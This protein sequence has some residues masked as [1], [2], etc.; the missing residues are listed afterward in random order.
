MTEPWQ[1]FSPAAPGATPRCPQPCRPRPGAPYPEPRW[2]AHSLAACEG[3]LILVDA[4]QG[5]ASTNQDVLAV[6]GPLADTGHRADGHLAP[7][8]ARLAVLGVVAQYRLP[9]DEEAEGSRG[10]SSRLSSPLG[11]TTRSAAKPAPLP[12]T[13][14]GVIRRP[15]CEPAAEEDRGGGHGHLHAR[16]KPRDPRASQST[17]LPPTSKR[18]LGR[19]RRALEAMREPVCLLWD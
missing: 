12:L 3:V 6:P 2:P 18:S 9:E 14:E 19:Q 4:T 17:I 7:R 5:E 11:G 10:K 16:H 15:L 1:D 13:A 8:L